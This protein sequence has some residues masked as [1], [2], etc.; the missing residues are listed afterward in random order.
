MVLSYFQQTRPER[1]IENNVTTGRQK[2]TDCFTVD[3][4]CN[5]CNTVFDAMGCYL[6][7]CPSQKDRPSLK[8]NEIMRGKKDGTRPNAP[9][10]D[11]TERLQSN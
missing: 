3:G 10:I 7:Y 2:K 9:R 8:D 5:H 6:H 4:I 1:K 11:P